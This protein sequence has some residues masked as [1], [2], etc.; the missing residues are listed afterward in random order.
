VCTTPRYEQCQTT[1]NIHDMVI[2]K[3][4]FSL[5]WQYTFIL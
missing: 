1:E 2:D 4:I 5:H 3:F